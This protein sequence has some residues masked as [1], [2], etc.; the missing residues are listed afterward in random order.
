MLPYFPNLIEILKVQL[1]NVVVFSI[2]IIF[3]VK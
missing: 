2:H 1:H 3:G